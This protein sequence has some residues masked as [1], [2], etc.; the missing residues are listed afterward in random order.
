M[1]TLLA[2]LVACTGRGSTP[3]DEN[4]A[5]S[6]RSTIT[7]SGC[8]ERSAEDLYLLRRASLDSN[9]E[10]DPSTRPRVSSDGEANGG[11][12]VSE[13]SRAYMPRDTNSAPGR[14]GGRTSSAANGPWPGTGTYRLTAGSQPGT[15]TDFQ[16]VVGSLVTI[17]GTVSAPE[18][19]RAAGTDQMQAARGAVFQEL[20]ATVVTPL[21]VRCGAP[22]RGQH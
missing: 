4:T 6:N 7:V 10:T 22:A 19:V 2:A 14:P 3:V 1:T 15:A 16:T 18:G 21:G 13:S 8:V 20:T 9:A 11:Q 17:T 12:M 5:G